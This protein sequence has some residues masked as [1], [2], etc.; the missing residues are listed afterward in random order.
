MERTIN[1]TKRS[2]DDVELIDKRGVTLFERS[3]KINS[4]LTS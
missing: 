1:S 4:T 3:T 2:L